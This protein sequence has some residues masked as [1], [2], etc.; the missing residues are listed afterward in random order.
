MMMKPKPGLV[1][2]LA[3]LLPAGLAAQ[4]PS[5]SPA[6]SAPPPEA[7]SPRFPAEV[8]QV[9]VDVVVTDKKGV[10]A[11]GLTAADF[12]VFE[13][14]KPQKVVSFDAVVVPPTASAVTPARPRIST[15]MSADVRTGRSFVVVFD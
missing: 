1:F 15:N 9:T 2:A 4:A 6:V 12:Q 8:E 10:P 5:P 3:L 11:T 14:D 7:A 13:D